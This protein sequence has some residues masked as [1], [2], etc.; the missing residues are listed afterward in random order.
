MKDLKIKVPKE[1]NRKE[2][3]LSFARVFTPYL[4]TIMKLKGVF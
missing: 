2:I 3:P 4:L 1:K